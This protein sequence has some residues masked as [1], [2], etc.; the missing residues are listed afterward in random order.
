MC[1]SDP[2][3]NPV[4]V[5]RTRGPLTENVHRGS[6]CVTDTEGTILHAAGECHRPVFTRSALKYFQQIPLVET[7]AYRSLGL[8]SEEL[9]VACASHSGE[10]VHVRLVQ[11]IL[12]KVGLREDALQCGVHPPFDKAA[13]HALI[14]KGASPTPIH[15]NCSGKHAAF[16][17]LAV[18]GGYST[19]DYLDPRHP[20]QKMI[21]QAVASITGH[22]EGQ[23][24][25]GVDGCSAPNYA[26][27]LHRMATGFARLARADA[28]YPHAS[29]ATLRVIRDAAVRHP[30]LIAGK[31]RYC[32]L[33]MKHGAPY[34]IGKTGADGVYGFGLLREGWGGAVKIDDGTSGAQYFVVQGLLYERLGLPYLAS[35]IEPLNEQFLKKE[36]RNWNMKAIG[37]NKF[38]FMEP[39]RQNQS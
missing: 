4:L 8:T 35:K 17:A 23:L 5:V 27:P 10:P 20:V 33:L 14:R 24:V 32:T 12:H 31:D 38:T 29:A 21:R 18:Y 39:F 13:R 25:E 36:I 6:F 11:R 30:Y 3:C 2:S 16:L 28:D 7:G 1:H 26:M 9:A 22:P 37:M 19:H 15:N 34:V